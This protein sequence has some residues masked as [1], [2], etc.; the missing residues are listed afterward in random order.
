MWWGAF[1]AGQSG[2]EDPNEAELA[3]RV[4]R[5]AR[6]D[7][8]LV[9]IFSIIMSILPFTAS[10]F[11][12]AGSGSASSIA[13]SLAVTFGFTTLYAIQTLSS[14]VSAESSILLSTLPLPRRDFSLITTLG[15]VRSADYIFAGSVASQTAAVAFLTRSPLAT[16]IMLLAATVNQILAVCT[17]LWFSRV[18]QR[19]LLRG[20]KSKVTTVLRLGFILMWG[21]LLV[22]VGFLLSI[23]WYVLPNL[24][25]MLLGAGQ[26]SSL[27]LGALYP[28][29]TGIL[30]AKLG[31][32]N[33]AFQDLSEASVVL[34]ISVLLAIVAGKW[35]LDTVRSISQG[36]GVK[37]ARLATE[38]RA[39]CT[40]RCVQSA[41][42]KASELSRTIVA[43]SSFSGSSIVLAMIA[44][45]F[46]F[47]TS[48]SISLRL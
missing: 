25:N 31:Y 41:W 12:T 17:A 40:Y 1:G 22:G 47:D 13:L 38:E 39:R 20:S 24:E 26:A 45:G 9:S 35:S 5:I 28:F 10:S 46:F 21:L 36:A 19:N 29:S 27:L 3:K 7:K 2:K 8:S 14:F 15:F 32:A 16:L 30:I 4:L 42:T 11:G 18:F 43:G 6:F 34:T 23:P 44:R 37:V 33:L 48:S